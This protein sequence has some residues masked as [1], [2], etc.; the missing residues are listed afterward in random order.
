MFQ[1]GYEFFVFSYCTFHILNGQTLLPRRRSAVLKYY[2]IKPGSKINNNKWNTVTLKS[3]VYSIPR[4]SRLID[5]GF[6]TMGKNN[7][8]NFDQPASVSTSSSGNFFPIRDD[9][10][11]KTIQ[12]LNRK[13]RQ[14]CLEKNMPDGC[15]EFCS[16][17]LTEAT[18]QQ[19]KNHLKKINAQ[20]P[21]ENTGKIISC[22]S[23]GKDNTRC[24]KK[25]K[26]LTGRYRHCRP[27]C[28]PTAYDWPTK[29]LGYLKYSHC[30]YIAVELRQCHVDNFFD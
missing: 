26:L 5:H 24:C 16:A 17:N 13:F 21:V 18:I 23:N 8:K 2:S 11:G 10:S 28:H 15:L 7:R 4:K 25:R 6:T 30:R 1:F 27:F 22:A 29:L 14:C 20:C 12:D 19:K 3:P 9:F